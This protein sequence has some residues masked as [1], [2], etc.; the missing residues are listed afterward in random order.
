M[1]VFGS[2]GGTP[3]RWILPG[4]D[5]DTNTTLATAATFNCTAVRAVDPVVGIFDVNRW[6]Q[7]L[8]PEAY[9]YDFPH[10]DTL[11]LHCVP[12]IRPGGIGTP[13][14]K[15]YRQFPS[16]SVTTHLDPSLSLTATAA[17]PP[18]KDGELISS[19]SIFGRFVRTGEF[20]SVRVQVNR[21]PFVSLV[22]LSDQQLKWK[23]K[24]EEVWDRAPLTTSG[25]QLKFECDWGQDAGHYLIQV[26]ETISRANMFNW[27][28]DMDDDGKNRQDSLIVSAHEFGHFLGLTDGYVR[29]GELTWLQLLLGNEPALQS[30]L[31]NIPPW[32][33]FVAPLFDNRQRAIDRAS[34]RCSGIDMMTYSDLYNASNVLMPNPNIPQGIIDVVDKVRN[35]PAP[36]QT[37]DLCWLPEYFD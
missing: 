5:E 17:P 15:G 25:T 34:G 29:D 33:I 20:I 10:D 37:Q 21:S 11:S 32:A 7:V 2:V 36:H 4:Y 30:K 22:E 14:Q 24:I 12:F 35:R 8:T 1:E 23:E 18:A 3:K 19:H 6:W 31:K 9:V 16:S 28:L 13:S 26:F 27:S